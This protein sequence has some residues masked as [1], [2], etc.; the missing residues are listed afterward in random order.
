MNRPLV[1]HDDSILPNTEADGE[2][3]RLNE[4]EL[5]DGRRNFFAWDDS[6]GHSYRGHYSAVKER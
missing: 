1:C 6:L 5:P 2:R 4:P 3:E